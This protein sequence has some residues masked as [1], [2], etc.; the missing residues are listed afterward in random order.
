[1]L[2]VLKDLFYFFILKN[3]DAKL[4]PK[5]EGQQTRAPMSRKPI[6]NTVV[7]LLHTPRQFRQSDLPFV[8][9]SSAN[10]LPSGNGETL[11]W[12]T[13]LGDWTLDSVTNT[14]PR[15]FGLA[16]AHLAHSNAQTPDGA[17]QGLVLSPLLFPLKHPWLHLQRWRELYLC[18]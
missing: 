1:M 5:V 8:N 13:T 14:D 7:S 10:N 17:P 9:F 15:Q 16:V 4:V 12:R 2:G 11:G 6:P 18:G 3:E